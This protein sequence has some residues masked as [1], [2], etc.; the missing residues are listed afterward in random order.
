[1]YLFPSI[2]L[3]RYLCVYLSSIH[4]IPTCMWM[5][6]PSWNWLEAQCTLLRLIGKWKA[7]RAARA[8][9]P[10]AALWPPCPCPFQHQGA[11]WVLNT[12]PL[13]AVTEEQFDIRALPRWKQAG[14]VV[15]GKVTG[16]G[17]S[18]AASALSQSLACWQGCQNLLDPSHFQVLSHQTCSSSLLILLLQLHLHWLPL[19]P[20]SVSFS[21]RG[22]HPCPVPQA[23]MLEI[24]FIS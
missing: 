5:S 17:Q 16:T 21:L 19:S 9:L 13:H 1:M 8:L 24:I 23:S 20:F 6:H 14:A 4:H 7:M 2:S 18:V 11:L 3:Y 15:Q 10:R 12:C 22:Y